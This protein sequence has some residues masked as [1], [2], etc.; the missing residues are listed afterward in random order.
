M[1][2][3]LGIYIGTS[4]TKTIIFD[5]KGI[6]IS[7]AFKDYPLYQPE[8]G[9]AEQNPEDWWQSVVST[10]SSAIQKSGVNNADIKGQLWNV[11][12]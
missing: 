3:V 11:M 4:G 7:I 2:Y 5:E 6:A 8:T 10:I 12:K 1:T 9:W